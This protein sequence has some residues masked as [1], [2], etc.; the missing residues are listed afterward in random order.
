MQLRSCWYSYTVSS[1][2]TGAERG[3]EQRG[4]RPH[5][6]CSSWWFCTTFVCVSCKWMA[7]VANGRCTMVCF[8]FVCSTPPTAHWCHERVTESSWAP[9]WEAGDSSA[10]PSSATDPSSTSHWASLDAVSSSR[11]WGCCVIWSGRLLPALK[12]TGG[13]IYHGEWHGRLLYFLC[14]PQIL[15][16]SHHSMN[17]DVVCQCDKDCSQEEITGFDSHPTLGLVFEM[18]L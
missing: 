9:S 14:I 16:R 4:V 13:V 17:T 7:Y 2:R 11:K 18:S 15:F 1:V 3:Q 8:V 12:L 6:P 10:C 5:S